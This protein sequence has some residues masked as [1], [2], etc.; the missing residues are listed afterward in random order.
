MIAEGLI[1]ALS[2]GSSPREAEVAGMQET[3]LAA[4][5]DVITRSSRGGSTD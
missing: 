4:G 3:M 2:V 5:R 1:R